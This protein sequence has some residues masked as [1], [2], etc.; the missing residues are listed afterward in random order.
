MCVCAGAPQH[1]TTKRHLCS[2]EHKQA[3]LVLLVRSTIQRYLCSREHKYR[4][5]VLPG[6][7]VSLCCGAAARALVCVWSVSRLCLVCVSSAS[8]LCGCCGTCLASPLASHSPGIAFLKPLLAP[9][10]LLLAPCS[11]LLA[12]SVL[13]Q[14]KELERRGYNAVVMLAAARCRA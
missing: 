4:L 12:L 14:I 2:R 9:C 3:T 13:P 8:R 10:S 6:A 11:L 7:Q 5:F 1:S